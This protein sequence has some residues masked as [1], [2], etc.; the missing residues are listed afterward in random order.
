MFFSVF[1]TSQNARRLQWDSIPTLRVRFAE[2]GSRNCVGG[3]LGPQAPSL[4]RRWH[5]GGNTF[6]WHWLYNTKLLEYYKSPVLISNIIQATYCLIGA[7][8]AF[9]PVLLDWCNDDSVRLICLVYCLCSNKYWVFRG[10]L[11]KIMRLMK[12]RCRSTFSTRER[13]KS[14]AGLKLWRV[15]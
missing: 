3:S 11:C 14:H 10:I 13:T 5:S 8:F 6:S 7:T 2:T 1:K 15:T 4:Q 12:S 9:T